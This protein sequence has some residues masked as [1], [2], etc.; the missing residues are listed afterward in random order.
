MDR[1]FSVKAV[2]RPVPRTAHMAVKFELRKLIGSSQ[3]SVNVAGGDLGRWIAPTDPT[4]GQNPGDVWTVTKVVQNLRAPA[5]YR[6]RVTFRWTDS[7]GRVLASDT[8]RSRVCVESDLRPDL[9]VKSVRVTN[10]SRSEDMYQAV[11]RNAG[12]TS[13]EGPFGVELSFAQRAHLLP[14][15]VAITRLGAHR[16]LSVSFSGPRC[17]P[18]I[19]PVMTVDPDHRVPDRNRQNNS[20]QVKCPGP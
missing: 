14:Q 4:L 6:M 11:I 19:A 7:R 16:S 12:A 1:S 18:A 20:Y 15:T 10:I 9:L 3:R 17:S 2:M 8:R 13:A 5:R